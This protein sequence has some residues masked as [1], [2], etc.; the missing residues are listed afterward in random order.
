[1]EE[2]KNK[3]CLRFD[4]GEWN[5]NISAI[6]DKSAN[7]AVFKQL[8]VPQDNEILDIV[9]FRMLNDNRKNARYK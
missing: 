5:E 3:I 4:L 2:I 8:I 1:M 9:K 7:W 6:W